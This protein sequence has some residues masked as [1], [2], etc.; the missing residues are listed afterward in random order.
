MAL[1]NSLFEEGVVSLNFLLH[2]L[3][4][5]LEPEALALDVDDSGVMEYSVK[6]SGGNGNIGED[7]VLL[8]ESLV[9]GKN[10]GNPLVTSGDEL[11]KQVSSLNVH[12]QIANFVNNEHL[13]LSERLELV[14]QTV[15]EMSLF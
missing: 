3:L 11:E 12:R 14:R 10:G 13:V 6:D 7:L 8:G 1:R 4:A 5:L 15:L 9:G 2:I